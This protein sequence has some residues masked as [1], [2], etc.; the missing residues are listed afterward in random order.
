MEMED[1]THRIAA[2]IERGREF[3]FGA[4]CDLG[5]MLL[6][7]KEA[8]SVLA[9]LPEDQARF[10]KYSLHYNGAPRDRVLQGIDVLYNALINSMLESEDPVTKPILNG[11][12]R[13]EPR[14]HSV[15]ERKTKST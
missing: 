5:I 15:I 12:D 10:A 4:Y 8:F 14:C 7:M 6:W 2:L 1:L 11:S 13:I 9:P 3:S